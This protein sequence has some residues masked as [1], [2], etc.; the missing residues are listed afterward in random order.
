MDVCATCGIVGQE[1]CLHMDPC[2][3]PCDTCGLTDLD[4]CVDPG[5]LFED[6]CISDIRESYDVYPQPKNGCASEYY[7]GLNLYH[8]LFSYRRL[9]GNQSW[10]PGLHM[11]KLTEKTEAAQ[12]LPMYAYVFECWICPKLLGK[13]QLRFELT[14]YPPGYDGSE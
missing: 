5:V 8:H 11:F 14:E 6:N 7:G 10:T 2:D 4:C 9:S 12:S 3:V 13:L 1:P